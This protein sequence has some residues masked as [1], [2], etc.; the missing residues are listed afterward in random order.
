M[1]DGYELAILIVV[2][3][4]LVVVLVMWI[5]P[6]WKTWTASAASTEHKFM[7]DRNLFQ[8]SDRKHS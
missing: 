1:S 7:T 4:L 2:S 8:H 5:G 3:V 6:R